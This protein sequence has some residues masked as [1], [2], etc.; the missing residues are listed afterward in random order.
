MAGIRD[1]GEMEDGPEMPTTRMMRFSCVDCR[2]MYHT[3]A[4]DGV[5]K[6]MMSLYRTNAMN[7]SSNTKPAR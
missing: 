3:A 7:A 5:Q 2:A 1:T 4:N 6:L